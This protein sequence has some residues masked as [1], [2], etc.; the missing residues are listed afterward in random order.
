[1]MQLESSADKVEILCD[2]ESKKVIQLKALTPLWWTTGEK[3]K[4]VTMMN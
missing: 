1:M 2:Y 4:D 3:L